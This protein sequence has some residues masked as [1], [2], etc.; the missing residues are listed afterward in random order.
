MD[1]T[2]VTL[3]V[4]RRF[5][6]TKCTF[7]Q[8]NMRRDGGDAHTVWRVILFCAVLIVAF[9]AVV[10]DA[11]NWAMKRLR[12][13]ERHEHARTTFFAMDHSNISFVPLGDG[14]VASTGNLSLSRSSLATGRQKS[15][16]ASGTATSAAGSRRQAAHQRWG[17]RKAA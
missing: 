5:A 10:V 2:A 16:F 7:W 17:G 11:V 4:R 15:S 14:L 12:Q 3:T 8:T 9:V 1:H 6:S 13:H